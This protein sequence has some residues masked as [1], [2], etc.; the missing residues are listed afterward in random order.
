[1][2]GGGFAGTIQVFLPATTVNE[3]ISLMTNIFG[4][5]CDLILNIRSHGTVHLN[6]LP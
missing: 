5:G 4:T 3:Y 2:H 1:V 6:S